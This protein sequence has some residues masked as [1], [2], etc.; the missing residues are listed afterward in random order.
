VCSLSASG[1]KTSRESE[2]T[3]REKKEKKMTRQKRK[4][5]LHSVGK[6][7]YWNRVKRR[8]N[9]TIACIIFISYNII[10]QSNHNKQIKH[11]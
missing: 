8:N 10:K 11:K 9:I 3:Q 7:L 4:E 6:Q 1:K 5:H 2:G